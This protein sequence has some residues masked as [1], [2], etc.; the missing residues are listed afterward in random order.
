[1]LEQAVNIAIGCVAENNAKYLGQSLRL[2]Q[3]ISWFA[4]ALARSDRYV[5]CVDGIADDYR[6]ALE[7]LGVHVR[8]VERFSQRHPPS[9]KLRFLQLPEIARAD[10]VLLLD[11]DTIVLRDPPLLAGR[12]GLYGKMADAP[13][14]P[15]EVFQRVFDAFA[16]VMPAPICRCSVG[17]EATIPYFNAGVLYFSAKA[18]RE[19]V[20]A[21]IRC[22]E[23]LLDRL[24]LLGEHEIY[25]E[26]TSLS[27]ALAAT[28]HPFEVAGN[29]LNFPVHFQDT[30]ARASLV[31]VDP[32]IIHYHSLCDDSGFICASSLPLVDHRIQEFNARLRR[33]RDVS[34][35]NRD[36]WNRRY[37]EN[38][39]LGSGIGSRGDCLAFKRELLSA[40]AARWTPSSIVD[41]G[42]G[43]MEVSSALPSQGY[44]GIDCS[45]V[46]V[47]INRRQFPDRQF[48]AVDFLTSNIEPADM[49][50]CLDVLIH[51]PSADV[52]RAFVDKLVRSAKQ[53][54]I[55]AGDDEDP[56]LGG[57]VFYHEPLRLTLERAGAM[58]IREVGGYRHV[59]VYE[60]TPPARLAN[61]AVLVLGMHRS[62][63]S[64]LSGAL[65]LLGL[66]AGRDLA[67]ADPAINARGYWEHSGIVCIHNALL[68]ELGS[69]WEDCRPLPEGWS[70][71]PG[72]APFRAALIA[73]LRRDFADSPFWLLKDPRLCRLL[74]LWLCILAE[75]DCRPAFVLNIRHPLEVAQSLKA[76]DGISAE[77]ACLLWMQHFL[78]SE[79]ATRG[80]PRALVAYPRLL[81]DWRGEARRLVQELG[82]PLQY[83][84]PEIA[85]KV[86]DFLSADLRRHRVVGQDV[87]DE[88]VLSLATAAYEKVLAVT[89]DAEI[90]AQADALKP[91]VDA[92][93]RV[94]APW[95]QETLAARFELHQ[96]A[97][98][99]ERDA[100]DQRQRVDG[101]QAEIRRIKATWSWQ[102][103]KPLRL[104]HTA[105][106]WVSAKLRG[107]MSS[108]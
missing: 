63:T 91:A 7:R 100:A 34:F 23:A 61:R 3:S 36:F 99:H 39:E 64:A 45:N 18:L 24:E 44:T 49:V 79:R 95:E 26:Q 104:L 29:E 107:P 77:R 1:M 87:A 65:A 101:L 31:G 14:V 103:T 25:C 12:P 43:D 58:N 35:D 11:C 74:P 68:D 88:E 69:S 106:R 41:V 13:T 105:Y 28:G 8:I 37:A 27:L 59:K 62:G 90:S 9:N 19:L 33:S 2:M 17:G 16:L 66:D 94:V 42:C 73:Q 5:C 76:R 32:F 102:I 93:L 86:D 70:S 15:L 21:W 89:T 97:A 92:I 47:E 96:V 78:E 85:G 72:V 52:Y 60:F 53:V 108:G 38:P 20:P 56:S 6:Q 54:G 22:N 71:L 80:H 46:V 4:P 67:P 57:I 84:D 10:G 81:A 55:V 98:R 48:L 82:L 50:V 75:L 40:V 30:G 83:D 51:L